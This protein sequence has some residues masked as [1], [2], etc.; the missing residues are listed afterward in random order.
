MYKIKVFDEKPF[1][2]ML[3]ATKGSHRCLFIPA[4]GPIRTVYPQ[5]KKGTQCLI[6]HHQALVDG[7]IEVVGF[8]NFDMYCNEDGRNH[9]LPL[10]FRASKLFLSRFTE[11][12]MK[13]HPF[14]LGIVGDVYITGGVDAHGWAKHLSPKAQEE[15]LHIINN[16]KELDVFKHDRSF[17]SMKAVFEGYKKG[18]DPKFWWFAV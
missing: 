15:V 3:E 8:P 6:E 1:A 7:H 5:Q 16:A 12:D 10:N 13:A 2:D 4:V 14:N 18:F 17:E 9:N 11:D